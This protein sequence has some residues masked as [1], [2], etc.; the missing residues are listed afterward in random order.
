LLESGDGRPAGRGAAPVRNTECWG[1]HVPFVMDAAPDA[2]TPSGLG[3]LPGPRIVTFGPASCGT[4]VSVVDS[5]SGP[6]GRPAKGPVSGY[7]LR[8]EELFL[9]AVHALAN[10]LD[11]CDPYTGGHSARVSTYAMAIGRALGLEPDL[12]ATLGLGGE[13]HDIGKIGVPQHLLTKAG[14]LTPAEYRA[15]MDHTTT[16]E[17]ILLP[18]LHNHP[19]VL[20]IVRSHH[21][22][23]D[24]HGLPDGLEGEQIPL[25]ARIVAVADTFD[26]MTS[27]RPYRAALTSATA[28]CELERGA[29]SQFDPECVAAFCRAFPTGKPVDVS[30]PIERW[31][32]KLARASERPQGAFARRQRRTPAPTSDTRALFRRSSSRPRRWSGRGLPFRSGAANQTCVAGRSRR[33]SSV[34]EE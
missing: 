21:E 32:G 26:A 8:V 7:S 5:R 12:I 25:A 10:A 11:A 1:S 14:K 24:G 28:L 9:N 19:T 17:K 27:D 33:F 18:L 2:A 15:V 6:T 29:G 23:W 3:S 20:E 16:G 34:F 31:T 22:R 30:G 4:L 13:L